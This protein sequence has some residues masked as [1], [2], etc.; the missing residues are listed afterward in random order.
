MLNIK[1]DERK[2][3]SGKGISRKEVDSEQS[4]ILDEE[5]KEMM[6]WYT[7]IKDLV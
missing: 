6:P 2:N 7:S 5:K 4:C 1:D 3:M